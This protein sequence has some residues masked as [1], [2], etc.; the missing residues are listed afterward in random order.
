MSTYPQDA[1]SMNIVADYLEE[2]RKQTLAANT[3]ELAGLRFSIL[4]TSKWTVSESLGDERRAELRT[5]LSNLRSLYLDKI[6]AI[7]MAFG[8]QIAMETKEEIERDVAVPDGMGE[9]V[10]PMDTDQLYF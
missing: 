10:L 6:D 7:A 8:V 1:A 3:E 4:L 2:K 5:E 9:Y